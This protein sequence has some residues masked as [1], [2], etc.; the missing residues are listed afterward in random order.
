MKPT[1]T[2]RLC[3]P[4]ERVIR[5]GHPW[6]YRDAVQG[7]AGAGAA[8]TLVDVRGRFIARGLADEGSIAMRIFTL[9]DEAV[10]QALYG[11]RIDRAATLRDRV[12][13]P[14][15]DAY[16]LLHGEGDRLPGFVCD[17][18]GTH[19]VLKTDGAGALAH[20]DEFARALRDML[21]ARGV[22]TLLLRHTARGDGEKTVV[23]WGPSPSDFVTVHERG[24]V[25]PVDLIHGQKTG[26]FLDQRESRARVRDLARGLRVLNLYG[27]T[28][29]F[30]IAAALGRACQV[31][32]VDVSR[33]AMVLAEEGWRANDLDPGKHL[34]VVADV[35][36]HLA[37]RTRERARFDLVIADPP[38]FA[39]REDSVA[40]ALKSYCALHASAIG[41][42]IP[43]GFYLAASCSSHVARGAFVD[44]V[45]EGARRAKRALQLLDTWGAPADHPRLPA[46]PEGDYL[47]VLLLRVE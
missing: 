46:F 12:V 21:E 5:D 37:A 9:R 7:A 31:E 35:A 13:P 36:S 45:I 8:V 33:G 30:S 39:P 40:A 4:L 20:A 47:K 29:G 19:A 15:T 23:L 6:V 28:G 10:D 14:D 25:L 2:L 27:Y 43:G 38:S 24:M 44:T 1:E 34:A 3:K 42:V 22:R 11:S 26:M 18:Y 16:R 41:L 17:V 32:T